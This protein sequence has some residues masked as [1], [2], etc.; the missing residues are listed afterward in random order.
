MSLLQDQETA[1]SAEHVEHLENRLKEL[2]AKSATTARQNPYPR[3]IELIH[4]PGW[5]T[6]AE[7][8]FFED[9]LDSLES[10]LD[11]IERDQRNLLKAAELVG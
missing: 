10:H 4:R 9:A 8:R 5:T 6:L 7:A 1:L 2:Q 3:L 11:S